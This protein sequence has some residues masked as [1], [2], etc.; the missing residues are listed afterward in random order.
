MPFITIL[1]MVGFVILK[2]LVAL[3]M[4]C[5]IGLIVAY[6]ISRWEE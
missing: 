5:V 2:I 6:I 3:A 4:I 1:G